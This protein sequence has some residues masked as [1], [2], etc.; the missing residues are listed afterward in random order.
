MKKLINDELQLD[1]SGES[2]YSDDSDKENSQRFYNELINQCTS[3][4]I[5]F[6]HLH[7]KLD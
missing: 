4:H 1:S 2:N 6:S 5:I 7:N 3:M